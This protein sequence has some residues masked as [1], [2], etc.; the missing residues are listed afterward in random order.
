VVRHN[1]LALF[2]RV[3][4]EHMRAALP[5]DEPTIALELSH[6]F[7]AL[8]RGSSSGPKVNNSIPAAPF[9]NVCVGS[10]TSPRRL[11]AEGRTVSQNFK[12]YD[13]KPLTVPAVPGS[14]TGA[15]AAGPKAEYLEYHL[16]EVFGK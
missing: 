15:G 2:G 5:D 14:W 11:P 4:H 7:A 9:T 8:H 10:T 6:Q 1:Q 13:G 12:T 3:F 16:S